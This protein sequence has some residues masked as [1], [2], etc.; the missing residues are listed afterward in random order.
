MGG[1]LGFF[2]DTTRCTNCRTCEVACKDAHDL[3]VGLR[4]RRVRAFEG[5]E[6][7]DV[8][9]YNIS[10]SCH[11]C[12]DPACVKACP[13]HA[14]SKRPSDG[15]V[16]HDPERCIGCRYCTWVCPY[17]APQYDAAAGIV[18]KCDMCL[19]TV[20]PGEAP[21]CVS[22]CPTRAIETGL[23]SEIAGRPGAS[24]EI[25]FLPEPM[26]TRPSSRYKVRREALRGATA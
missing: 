7:P 20:A 6:F 17:A 9:A 15:I 23:L 3:A 4:F 5:G 24:L 21:I 14:Y 2:V 10:M 11:H 18:R 22:A 26:L 25:R 19:D 1:Q 16:V 13:A 12:E 8:Y